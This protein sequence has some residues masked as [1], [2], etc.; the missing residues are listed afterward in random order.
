MG[1]SAIAALSATPHEAAAVLAKATL[2]AA[3]RLGLSNRDLARVLGTSEASVS[4]LSDGRGLREGR[5][6]TSLALLFVR[7]FRSLDAVM[8]GNDANARAWFTAANHHLGGVPAALVA[9]P[10]GLVNVV[11]YLDAIRGKL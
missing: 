11:Q 5:A 1:T 6:E 2:A 3:R 4:R 8:G 7:L 10:E 9:S